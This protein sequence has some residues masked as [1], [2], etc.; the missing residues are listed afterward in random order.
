MCGIFGIVVG[1]TGDWTYPI[2]IKSVH[3]LF[4][5]SQKRGRDASGIALS[6]PDS[7]L[8]QKV[9]KPASYL[10]RTKEYRELLK[11]SA[12]GSCSLLPVT[13]VGHTRME[14]DGCSEVK[15]NNQPIIADGLVGLHNGIVVNQNILWRNN[16]KLE[17]KYQVD[18][19]IIFRLLNNYCVNGF[20]LIEA[21]QKMFQ[22]IEG[23]ASIAA[24]FSEYNSLLLAT[25]NGSLYQG[26]SSLNDVFLFASEESILKKLLQ[27]KYLQKLTPHLAVKQIPAGEGL[28]VNL[29]D[30]SGEKF[31][32]FQNKK[33]ASRETKLVPPRAIE[34][35]VVPNI[36]SNSPN[37]RNV[38]SES[39]ITSDALVY[40]PAKYFNMHRCTK[41]VLPATFPFIEFDA[42]GECNYCRAYQ[43][44]EVLGREN[45]EKTVAPYRR[46][47]G[48]P[49]CI[50]GVSGGRDSI[51]AL[52]YV[53]TVLKM[54][55]LAYTYDWGMVTDMA[56]R[57]ISRI[58]GK[59]GVEHILVSADI[60][61]KREYVRKNVSAWL[62]RPSLGVI[63]LFMAGDKQYFY[64]AQKLKKETGVDLVILGENM[65]ERTNFKT[66]FA[67]VKPTYDKNHVYTLDLQ[68]KVRL[69]LFYAKQ[70]LLNHSYINSSL[71]DTLVAFGCYYLMDRAY[72]NIYN[73]IPWQ[74]SEVITTIRN[75]YDWEL[76][77]DT[78]STWRIGD[79]TAA[80]YNY[81]YLMV[82]GFTE[83]DA[84]FSNLI[85]EGAISRENGL[86][87]AIEENRPR[88][89]T[90]KWYLD[91]IQLDM[92]LE[93]VLEVI[94]KI[95]QFTGK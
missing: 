10:L 16:P 19:E 2:I 17:R 26:K 7:I 35:V 87:R 18:S 59:L 27:K 21:T 37:K 73:Y 46:S 65:Y 92:S 64:Y 41:C 75:E 20:S 4:L 12:N 29:N 1:D 84:F 80:F 77:E 94:R 70:Y 9:P 28:L 39:R 47:G 15:D 42:Q 83:N 43:Q 93:Q 34:E 54:N 52:H 62:K 71:L 57:N 81:I 11:F 72:L 8:V 60:K 89:P 32:L 13:V 24:L 48:R 51:Y 56:R 76:T 3:D 6:T 63:P 69:I 44:H 49:D 91:T 79:G 5:L 68:G 22:K 33:Y 23:M 78:E 38:P 67:G 61:K 53:K 85:R 88:Y 31:S 36:E 82:A 95:P 50:I 74:E 30:C 14:T 55:P 40:D 25:N 58:C 45:L 66:G 90:M 86:I